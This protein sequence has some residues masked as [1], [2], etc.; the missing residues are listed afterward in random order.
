[1]PQDLQSI[2][3]RMVEAGESEDDIALVIK[4]YAAPASTPSG[5]EPLPKSQPGNGPAG[6]VPLSRR[7]EGASDVLRV[8]KENPGATGATIAGAAAAPFTGGLSLGPAIAAQAAIGA[9]GSTA[10]H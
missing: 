10:G 4:H 3:Q 8:A 6:V 1:M 7:G 2:V 5:P 9:G